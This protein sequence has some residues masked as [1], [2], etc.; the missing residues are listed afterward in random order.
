MLSQALRDVL[1]AVGWAPDRSVP[2]SQWIAALEAGGF[3]VVP[4]AAAIL[5]NFGGLTLPPVRRPSDPHAPENLV[6]DPLGTA[7]PEAAAYWEQFLGKKL[8][9]IAEVGDQGCLLLA[10]TGEVYT[11]WDRFLFRDGDSLEDALENTLVFGRRRPVELA[12][13]K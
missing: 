11:S 2:T 5:R 1:T 10:E 8:T 9:P 4:A 3:S 6:F 13:M 7:D 12:S